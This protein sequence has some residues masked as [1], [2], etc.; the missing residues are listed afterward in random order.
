MGIDKDG[1]VTVEITHCSDYFLSVD[2]SLDP[3]DKLPVISV[4]QSE[5]ELKVG[6]KLKL[7]V[8]VDLTTVDVTYVS[9]NESIVTVSNEGEIE[10]VGAGE[11]EVKI[12][13]G[14]ATDFVKIKVNNDEP[15]IPEESNPEDSQPET[16]KP[17]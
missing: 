2:D 3:N 1:Y 9:L 12:E 4:E 17:E 10:A 5:V 11:T 16:P 15:I 14:K 7:N 6:E 13:A 8:K